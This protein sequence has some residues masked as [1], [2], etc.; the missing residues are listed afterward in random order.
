M[1]IRKA[2]TDDI[3]DLIQ[4]RIEYL[5]E[6]F[7]TLDDRQL[8]QIRLQLDSYFKAHLQRDFI[9]YIA[10]DSGQSIASAFLVIQERPANPRFLTGQTG[11]L[12]N[13][14]TRDKYRR[15]GIA[16]QLLIK[17]ID[18]ARTLSLSYIELT[19]TEDG[20]HLYNSLG[21]IPNNRHDDMILKLH[22]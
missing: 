7:G 17:V 5:T 3:N 9:A 16:K 10:Q 13:V 20:K 15:Q 8:S 12:L 19:T 1:F 11:L 22:E 6:H 4:L 2:T 18:E 14:Y 21:F